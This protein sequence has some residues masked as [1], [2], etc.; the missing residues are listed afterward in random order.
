[1]LFKHFQKFPFVARL[2]HNASPLRMSVSTPGAEPDSWVSEFWIRFVTR[3][4]GGAEALGLDSRLLAAPR[5]SLA[6][7][8]RHPGEPPASLDGGRTEPRTA[9]IEQRAGR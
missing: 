2:G 8:G 9:T 1:V 7:V 6:A 5:G 4:G 3:L